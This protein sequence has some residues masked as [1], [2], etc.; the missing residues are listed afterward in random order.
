MLALMY[1]RQ[2]EKTFPGG[3]RHIHAFPPQSIEDMIPRELEPP[4]AE[5]HLTILDDLDH[6]ARR[7]DLQSIIPKLLNRDPL[8]S[9]LLVGQ[10][11]MGVITVPY[12]M[13]LL[14]LGGVNQAEFH[15]IIQRRLAKAQVSQREIEM[16]YAASQGN[17]FLASAASLSVRE[18]LVTLRQFLKAFRDF[19]Y[20]PIL[21]LDGKPFQGG[22]V[23]PE[24]VVV[25][26]SDINDELLTR[27]KSDPELLRSL[28]PRKFEEVVA[29][30]LEKQGYTVELTPASGDG[31]FDMY[32][33]KHEALG[34]FLYLVEC[35]RY[36]PPNKVGVQV[37]RALHGVV[38]QK[39]AT[40]G[41]IVTTA[42]FTKGAKEFQHELKHQLQ[43]HDY[44]ELQ[45]WLGII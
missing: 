1:A 26:V 32:A 35:K 2:A 31:G 5:R 21:G 37:V 42:F 43:L 8:L 33:A 38:Q 6:A 10:R 24:K 13:L 34:Q 39:Q 15:E 44:I 36:T 22:L 25:S 29:E 3:I 41:V 45:K 23:V 27:L 40:S 28:S 18:G 19:D 16:L 20:S 14:S 7:E 4:Q 17:P 30:L 12:K 9:L 11:P